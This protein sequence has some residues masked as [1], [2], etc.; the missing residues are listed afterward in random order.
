M[1]D[2]NKFLPMTG[3]EPQTSDIKSNR[4]TN[5]ATT[6]SHSNFILFNWIKFEFF[7]NCFYFNNSSKTLLL[8][9]LASQP[10]LPQ[11]NKHE[12]GRLSYICVFS[13][14][15]T[16]FEMQF[17]DFGS[18]HPINCATTTALNF[19][20]LLKFVFYFQIEFRLSGESIYNLF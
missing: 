6:T 15:L 5:W 1:F 4:S 13:T 11:T 3:F 9:T 18:N 20:L 2:I 8:C 12:H 7:L 16:G 10:A 14:Q 19:L 17:S